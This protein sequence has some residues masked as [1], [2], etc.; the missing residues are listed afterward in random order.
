L[1]FG[2]IS[3]NFSMSRHV[4]VWPRSATQC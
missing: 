3:D 4:R 2:D 1:Y